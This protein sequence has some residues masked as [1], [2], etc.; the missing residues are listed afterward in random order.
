MPGPFTLK[1]DSIDYIQRSN[2][3]FA[4]LGT[5]LAETSGNALQMDFLHIRRISSPYKFDRIAT[6]YVLTGI[7]E[8]GLS[9][10]FLLRK[11]HN[12][13]SIHLGIWNDDKRDNR[14]ALDMLSI[15]L[16]SVYS[17]VDADPTKVDSS[18]RFARHA[19]AVGI[20]S[21][22]I[23][24]ET[25]KNSIDHLP[26]DK[27][28]NALSVLTDWQVMV[29]AKPIQTEN[30]NKYLNGLLVEQREIKR[31]LKDEQ[32]PNP[33]A[34]H[35]FDLIEKEKEH[36]GLSKEVG[37]WKTGVYLYARESDIDV[38][39]GLWKAVF[40]GDDSLPTP[41][42]TVEVPAKSGGFSPT[43]RFVDL[44][45]LPGPGNYV[46]HSRYLS[47]LNSKQLSAYI[48]FPNFEL[49]G[50]N[51]VK[52]PRFDSVQQR[53]GPVSQTISLGKIY[54]G[55]YLTQQEY[56]INTVDLTRH[57]LV[58]GTTGSG[59]TNS[60]FSILR[61]AHRQQVNFLV[62]ESAKAEYRSLLRDKDL[63]DL[64]IFTLGNELV[65]PFRINPF[66][67]LPGIP[68]S[69]HVDL[70]RS[71]FSASFG[72]WTPLP[73]VL[74]QCL[75]RVYED[76]GWNLSYNSNQRLKSGACSPLAYPTMSDL[77]YK[78]EP[79][80]NSL[81][82]EQK[83]RD[84]I[85]AA[86]GTRINSLRVGG[87]G[88]ML[89]THDSYPMEQL[90]NGPAILEMEGIGDDDDKA[91]LIGIF[92]IFLVEYRRAQP[93]ED[94][95]QHLL[96]IE[97]AH[98]LLKNAPENAPQ[99]QSNPRGKAVETFANL[100]AEIRAYDQ[101][102]IVSDQIPV[103]L[104]PE[105]IKNTNLKIVH[106]I[107]SKDD[108]DSLAG[109]MALEEE[110][111]RYFSILSQGE[112]VV[113]SEGDDKPLMVKVA[114][115][116]DDLSGRSPDD[117]G[118][119]AHM[120]PDTKKAENTRD[121]LLAEEV[122]KTMVDKKMIKSDFVRFVTTIA[123]SD[124][125]FEDLWNQLTHRVLSHCNGGMQVGIVLECTLTGLCQWFA[126]RQGELARWDY[127]QVELLQEQLLG[128]VGA[129]LNR[130]EIQTP[131][132]LLRET[133]TTLHRREYDPYPHCS[134]VCPANNGT[135]A[136]CRYRHSLE[137]LIR[138]DENVRLQ[139]WKAACNGGNYDPP[140][141]IANGVA[142]HLVMPRHP[143]IRRRIAA[144]YALHMQ[145]YEFDEINREPL[146]T[147][148]SK[149]MS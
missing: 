75:H 137:E 90:L 138:P 134:S 29:M 71:V 86:L 144:C 135:P 101:G 119:R 110:D 111:S 62:I 57:S 95:R 50:L 79:V 139:A 33:L 123:E 28:L 38:L 65:S 6:E 92:F 12:D 20:P 133:L 35:Y 118:V 78:I 72:M 55:N 122:A 88:K 26:L 41:I 76:K 43:P 129:R 100:L 112:A 59:K 102:V 54:H 16:K 5:D 24:H 22:K 40:S 81:G 19:I 141:N 143:D 31:M 44:P 9:P 109:A 130:R 87:K 136:L 114:S 3:T 117:A 97:E 108:R 94:R 2:Q 18:A 125:S 7:H 107:I 36:V 147:L 51:I 10:A 93:K 131:L 48:H 104:A 121:V 66:E 67:I 91:F 47:L 145:R 120:I 52:I 115:A 80:V 32:V 4:N 63:K 13:L 30:V 21:S 42:K 83:S 37:A 126:G 106:R 15:L 74:E 39:C 8:V 113:F 64:K 61:A 116:K 105:I 1:I 98:R 96:V 70:L 127:S 128:L 148:I 27:L 142:S 85:K 25:E 68:V 49:P 89:D 34:D 69:V 84:D 77:Y 149:I 73:Q 140:I 45:A 46:H 58:C 60:I 124:G 11:R 17:Q 103:K 53:T 99:D 56:S 23:Y 82:Y 132:R 14:A 146:S